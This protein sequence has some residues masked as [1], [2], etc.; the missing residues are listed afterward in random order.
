MS[1]PQMPGLTGFLL[2]YLKRNPWSNGA[3]IAAVVAGASCSVLVQYG[4]RL[5]VN[6]MQSGPAA[7]G[8]RVWLSF[9]F[10]AFLIAIEAAAWRSAGWLACRAIVKVGVQLRLDLFERLTR[11]GAAYFGERF[12]GALGSRISACSNAVQTI[13][14][15]MI[16]NILPPCTAFVGAIV[17]LS[18]LH[19]PMAA[20]LAPAVLALAAVLCRI[21]AKGRPLHRDYARKSAETD[22]QLVDV[23]SN[24]GIV[25]AF[26]GAARE[27]DRLAR[28]LGIEADAHVK[29]ALYTER[30]RAIHDVALWGL[31]S[32]MLAW[33][34]LLWTDG[35]VSA[36]DVVVISSLTFTI[37]HG[38]RDLALAVIGLTDHVSRASEA[39]AE[40][41]LPEQVRDTEDAQ[42]VIPLGGAVQFDNVT[43]DYGSG[44]PALHEFSLRILPGQ[45]IGIV[46]P[47][48]S[49]KSTILS[50]VQR[51]YD[52]QSGAVYVDGQD[53]RTV[54]QESL[55]RMIAVVPQDVSLFHRTL[56]ENIRYGRPDATDEEVLA[57]A[58]AARCDEFVARMP[59][60]YQTLVG[61]RGTKLSGGQRQRIGIARAILC[62]A[63]IMIFD[64]ATSA[65]DS[66]S[67]LLI[68]QALAEAMQGRTVISVAH[69]LSTLAGFDRV[70]VVK[71]GRIVEDG[72][73]AML[74]A[75]QGAFG[76]MWRLQSESFAA[77]AA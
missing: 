43:F 3:A 10:F 59:E 54:T 7:A 13:E 34:V 6:S 4:M 51:L 21:G 5:L 70:I 49:G 50:L 32:L 62:N 22:G 76:H 55:H 9:L 12:S 77:V 47:S 30:M 1:L 23:V 75:G 69:R 63:P 19:W 57:A 18:R 52:V 41:T 66:E 58:R 8:D 31:S 61:E 44:L 38:S 42:P 17:I 33:A 27:R 24:I 14:S 15:T 26:S 25:R 29:S 20:M 36:G 2:G 16:W 67:E 72:H 39:L 68:Q 46:G 60:G 45:K 53:V 73:P 56:I 65:L 74:K 48:G 37:L 64:E 28:R 71:D 11:Q 40:L 35:K